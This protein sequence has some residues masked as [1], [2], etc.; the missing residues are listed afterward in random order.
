MM[1]KA[2]CFDLDGTVYTGKEP[3]ESAVTFI[4]QLQAQ[5]IEPFY[6]TNN[7]SKTA[8]QFQQA[9]A[10]IQIHAPITHIYSS[11]LATGKYIAMNHAGKTVSMIGSEGLQDALARENVPVVE[12]GGDIFVIGIDQN[13]N[14]LS[15]AKA[16]VAMQNGAIFVST[17]P[18]IKFPSE[19]GFLPGNGAFTELVSQV[20]G[21]KPLYIGKP[22]P[23]MLTIIQE[24]HGFAKDEMVMVG[25]NYDTD[26]LCGITF[27][28]D[29]IHVNTGVTSTAEAKLKQ[30]QATHHVQ[31]LTDLIPK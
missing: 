26:I 24:E 3:I 17:N 21:V 9:L 11:A 7:A 23:V 1:Y 13:L 4:H 12:E 30:Q 15:L 31:T 5:G 22:S 10:A 20:S 6:I 16:A 29:T 2:Y 25:D 8:E 18:D 28:I 19:Y 14:Y 27:G